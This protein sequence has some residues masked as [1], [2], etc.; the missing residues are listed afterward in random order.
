M[1]APVYGVAPAASTGETEMATANQA[2]TN[3]AVDPSLQRNVDAFCAQLDT[4][5]TAHSGK[6]VVFA[7]SQLVKV[8][9]SLSSAMTLGYAQFTDDSFLVQRV[10][11]LRKQ[12][13]FHA[14]CRV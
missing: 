2:A 4:L 9:D 3:V 12:I 8:C 14:T 1:A 7:N 5:L 13:D 11:P 10:E 6:Y